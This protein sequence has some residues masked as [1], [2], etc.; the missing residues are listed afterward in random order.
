MFPGGLKPNPLFQRGIKGDS[1]VRSRLPRD[2]SLKEYSRSLRKNMTNAEVL[3][4]SRIRRKSLGGYQFYRQRIIGKYIVDFYCHKAKLV[5]EVDGGQHYSPE[6][7]QK[8][9]VRDSYMT[10]LGLRV[11]RFSDR[12]IHENLDVVMETIWR[13]LHAVESP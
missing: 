13:S 10:W 2:R 12:E 4:W 5:I 8:D 6:G 1:Q 7:K 3:L 11:L 9:M